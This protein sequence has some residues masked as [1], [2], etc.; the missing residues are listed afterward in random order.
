MEYAVLHKNGQL[1]DC[2]PSLEQA[3]R[4]LAL[5]PDLE[6]VDTSKATK[7]TVTYTE[8]GGPWGYGHQEPSFITY[9]PLKKCISNLIKWM[10]ETARVF[11]PDA[12]DI[13][14]YFRHCSLYVAGQDK[15]KW[16]MKQ[17]D[18]INMKTM[19]V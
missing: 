7:L 8:L 19:Y 5:Y 9:G 13:R 4:V 6:L 18:G 10:Q 16:L 3:K 12:R 11:G 15:T 14:D 2:Y 17:V 1:I